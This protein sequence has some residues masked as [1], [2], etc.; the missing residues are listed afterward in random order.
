MI[1][2]NDFTNFNKTNYNFNLCDDWG[3]FHIDEEE[4]L[5]KN[6]IIYMHYTA[7]PIPQY[8]S[9]LKSRPP[10]DNPFIQ[11][12]LNIV[13][14]MPRAYVTID[15]VY[16]SGCLPLAYKKNDNANN[17]INANNWD[18]VSSFKTIK[19]GLIFGAMLMIYIFSP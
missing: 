6:T 1:S 18:T 14:K 15:K 17:A 4:H 7:P 5:L 16:P 19:N 10:V 13:Q 2:Y 11:K 12:L 9:I 8:K 3:W